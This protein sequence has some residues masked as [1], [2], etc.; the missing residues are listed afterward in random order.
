MSAPPGAVTVG[1]EATSATI[2]SGTCAPSRNAGTTA[3]IAVLFASMNALVAMA[4]IAATR[5]AGGSSASCPGICWRLGRG[6]G[7]RR[8]CTRS[9]G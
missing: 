6:A 3:P 7:Y 5:A 2:R 1:N 9:R 4:G 8:P